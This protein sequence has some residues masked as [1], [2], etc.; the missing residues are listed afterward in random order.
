MIW[1]LVICMHAPNILYIYLAAALPND[2]IILNL[3]R[4]YSLFGAGDWYLTIRPLVQACIV[5]E[6]FGYGLGFTAFMVYLLYI[7]K[8]EYKTS[9]YAIST[10]IMAVGLMVPG[11]L[12]G[13]VQQQ[14]GYTA[15]FVISSIMTIPGMIAIFFL[16]IDEE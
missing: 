2:T 3:T 4:L 8:G 11:L 12:S 13:L 14:F 5:V 6:Q 10:G 15:L 9:H 7:A 1:T 16:P